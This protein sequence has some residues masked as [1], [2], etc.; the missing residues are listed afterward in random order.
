MP[1]APAAVSDPGEGGVVGAWR[2]RSPD[3][4]TPTSRQNCST[5]GWY[6]SRVVARVRKALVAER[7]LATAAC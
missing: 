4:S 5:L 3:G 7:I 6:A 1:P 2:T